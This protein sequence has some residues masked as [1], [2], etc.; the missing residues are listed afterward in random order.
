MQT[1]RYIRHVFG[2]PR[3]SSDTL[4][5]FSTATDGISYQDVVK[6]S[7]LGDSV[8]Y[9]MG[10]Q[11]FPKNYELSNSPLRWLIVFVAQGNLYFGS[12]RLA[13]G[14]FVVVPPSH[15]HMLSSKNESPTYYWCTT[16]D[17]WLINVLLSCGYNAEE[18]VVGHTEYSREVVDIFEKAIYSLHHGVDIRIYFVGQIAG[19]ISYFSKDIVKTQKVSECLIERCLDFI[20]VNRGNVT[21]DGVA[22][23]HHISRRYLYTLFKEYRNISPTEYIM[24]IRMQAADKYLLTTNFSLSKIAEL[25]GYS[26]YK[27]FTRAY[28]N[29]YSESPLKRRNDYRR[30]KGNDIKKTEDDSAGE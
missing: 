4:D 12:D 29:Y 7:G 6:Y 30:Q 11:V 25:L 28:K 17:E 21:V 19:I 14:D 13:A 1:A 3:I 16:N 27:H 15:V 8:L 18:M 20:E 10:K 23:W 22:N 9:T 2:K 24:K 5:I 26:D